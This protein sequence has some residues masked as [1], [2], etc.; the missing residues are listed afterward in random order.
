MV[1]DDLDIVRIALPEQKA[2]AP[3][4]I[5]GGLCQSFEPITGGLR[6]GVVAAPTQ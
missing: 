3:A 2:D 6:E 4:C 5:H 1:V